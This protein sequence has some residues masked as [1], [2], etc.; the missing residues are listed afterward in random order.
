MADMHPLDLTAMQCVG[1][2]VQ[3]VADDAITTAD[4][5]LLQCIDDDL[6]NALAHGAAAWFG[7]NPR[8]DPVK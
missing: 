8:L 2:M 1:D 3:G 5:R 7:G 4:A 6:G